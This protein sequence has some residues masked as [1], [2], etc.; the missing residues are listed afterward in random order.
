MSDL[1]ELFTSESVCL[2]ALIERT[3]KVAPKPGEIEYSDVQEVGDGVRSLLDNAVLAVDQQFLGCGQCG[4]ST[5]V[6]GTYQSLRTAVL[7]YLADYKLELEGAR[8][9]DEEV[10]NPT[11]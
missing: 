10:L 9:R 5:P 3:F 2:S 7:G 1:V 4:G 8:R 11:Y 6:T